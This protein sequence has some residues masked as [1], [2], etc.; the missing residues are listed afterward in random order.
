RIALKNAVSSYARCIKEM[1]RQNS[2]LGAD[3][4][5]AINFL[6]REG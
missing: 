4:I 3:I 6:P 2:E 5:T 1:D